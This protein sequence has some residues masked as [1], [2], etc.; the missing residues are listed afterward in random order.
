MTSGSEHHR[1]PEL[2]FVHGDFG[3]GFDTW[4]PICPLLAGRCRAVIV[5]R[6]GFGAP[7][8]EEERFSIAHD[9]SYI[10]RAVTKMQLRS[11]QHVGHA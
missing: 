7:I 9:A 10:L 11:L 4:G 5:D 1:Q 3:D 6:P 8:A 2:L